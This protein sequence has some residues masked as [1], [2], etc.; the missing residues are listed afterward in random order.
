MNQSI[1]TCKV[2][3]NQEGKKLQIELIAVFI[4]IVASI[5]AIFYTTIKL[6]EWIRENRKSSFKLTVKEAEHFIEGKSFIH[7]ILV[8]ILNN[9][10]RKMKITNVRI[11][12]GKKNELELIPRGQ[13]F[14]YTD[15]EIGSNETHQWRSFFKRKL[16]DETDRAKIELGID[17]RLGKKT[18][19]FK[20]ISVRCEPGEFRTGDIIRMF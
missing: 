12:D 16:V 19:W 14:P 1:K 10:E 17:I 13:T 8:D 2:C 15:F 18:K 9:T 5:I 20:T 7:Y 6:V 11:R 3:G 4:S